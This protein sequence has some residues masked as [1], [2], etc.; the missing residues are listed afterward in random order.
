MGGNVKDEQGNRK[1]LELAGSM[2]SHSL[3][4]KIAVKR[5]NLNAA[6]QRRS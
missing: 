3:L 2:G 1:N 4:Q 5:G 6:T